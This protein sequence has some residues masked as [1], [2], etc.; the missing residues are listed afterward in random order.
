MIQDIDTK[1][2]QNAWSARPFAERMVPRIVPGV[3]QNEN[4]R[5]EGQSIDN[6][7]E[8]S[9]SRPQ[10]RPR[11]ESPTRPNDTRKSLGQVQGGL[12][13]AGTSFPKVPLSHNPI[14][15]EMAPHQRNRQIEGESHNGMNTGK[16]RLVRQEAEIAVLKLKVRELEQIIETMKQS[17]GNAQADVIDLIPHQIEET[18]QEIPS[19]RLLQS[20][21]EIYAQGRNIDWEFIDSEMD[22]AQV[23][24]EV[25]KRLYQWYDS[26]AA[27]LAKDEQ[28]AQ[29]FILLYLLSRLAQA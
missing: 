7:Q 22:Y 24:P 12:S 21:E 26:N 1:A 23:E 9:A 16:E 17:M 14:G 27:L 29:V 11:F 3:H 25:N 5:T 8:T 20:A 15:G 18:L 13:Q 6:A 28:N 19:L 10:K 4:D 2:L